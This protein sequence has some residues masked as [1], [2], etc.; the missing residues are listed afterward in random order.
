MGELLRVDVPGSLNAF[1][2]MVGE[3]HHWNGWEG[4]R[5]S[6][7]HCGEQFLGLVIPLIYRGEELL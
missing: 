5:Y 2:I 7:E 6:V 1:A 3:E 4:L